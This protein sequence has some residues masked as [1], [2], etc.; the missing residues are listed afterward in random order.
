M[1][2]REYTHLIDGV[3]VPTSSRKWIVRKS[4]ATGLTV[5]QFADGNAEDCNKGISAARKAFDEGPW[6]KLTGQERS[7]YLNLW[8]DKIEERKESLALIEAEEVGKP[9]RFARGDIEGGIGLTRYAAGLAW[10]MHGESVTNLGPNKTALVVREPIGVVAA[11]IPW[12]FPAL[13]FAQK[14]PFALAA[15]CTTVAKP[16]E[17]T[18]GT[19][20]EIARLA[21][22]AG[23]PPGAI[24]VVTGY[25]D[26]VGE[27]LSRSPDI[28]MICFTGS[29]RVGRRII[30]NSAE[31]LKKV[32][33]ELGGK[34]AN[35]IFPDAD[36]ED[37]IDGTLMGIF[38]NQG[39]VCCSGTRLLI[40]EEIADQF[41]DRLIE[42]TKSLRV[43]DPLDEAS[44]LGA[45]ISAD[46]YSRVQAYIKKGI[47]EGAKLLTGG[48]VSQK[49]GYFIAPT[50]LDGVTPEMTVYRD[51]IF[52]PVLSVIRFKSHED[53]V[54]LANDT[55]YGL[56]N[57]VWS[58]NVDTV[59]SLSG[60]LKSGT[61]WIN[62][63]IDGAPQLPFGGYKASGFGR[64][65]GNA[66]F[67][68]FTQIKTVL[69]HAGKRTPVFR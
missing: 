53:A 58:K 57:A 55:E 12:N 23:I 59:L 10:Q 40:H 65:M 64:E 60:R 6:P 46:H 56:S 2:V 68:E 36:L 41:L 21:L 17:M 38:F 7:R 44:D 39:E 52:G 35:I 48:G 5:S 11:I 13:I 69:I 3:E 45:M 66:G 43:G 24:N 20:V 42:R 19:A 31:T 15:G 25:G 61:V 67:E 50:I 27:T 30:T 18:S 34:A 29:T 32:S 47:E 51:E 1:N 9:I 22:E 14:V 49:E 26:P 16:S 4:P 33:L 54:R 37:A 63:I 8:A 28:D 62:T